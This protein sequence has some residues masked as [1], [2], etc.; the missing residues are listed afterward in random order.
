MPI[1]YT[2]PL[3]S[4][5]N[6]QPESSTS[7]P[8]NRKR[9]YNGEIMG[10]RRSISPEEGGARL[11]TEDGRPI[12]RGEII[13]RLKMNKSQAWTAPQDIHSPVE[14]HRLLQQEEIQHSE[15]HLPLL[16][17]DISTEQDTYAAGIDI[18]RPR[19]ALH[20]GDFRQDGDSSNSLED[21]GSPFA[22]SPPEGEQQDI[23][24]VLSRSHVEQY[25]RSRSGLGSFGSFQFLPPTSPLIHATTNPDLE[26]SFGRQR[27][28]S[29]TRRH[30]FSPFSLQT[31]R[32]VAES[33][34]PYRSSPSHPYQAH[35]PLRPIS[36]PQPPRIRP[37]GISTSTDASPLQH[38]PMVGSYEESILRGRMSTTPSR[39][40]DFIAQLG[41]LG[42]GKC[43][44]SLRCP[45]HVTVPFPAVFYSYNS[46]GRPMDNSPSPYV[47]L[48]DIENSF[49]SYEGKAP[50]GGCYRIPQQGQLQMIIKNPNKTAV[51]LFLVPYNLSDMEPG[52][53]TFIRQR[54]YSAGPMIDMP[55][56]NRKNLGTDRPEAAISHSEDP[57]ERPTLRYLI[58]LHI[59]CPARGRY[60]L[61][62]SIRVVFANRVVDGKEK[63]RNEVQ[64]PEPRYVPYK[65]TVRGDTS[66]MS[67]SPRPAR[68]SSSVTTGSRS[69][70]SQDMNARRRSTPFSFGAIGM[71]QADGLIS[72]PVPLRQPPLS[73]AALQRRLSIPIQQVDTRAMNLAPSSDREDLVAGVG[74]P[75]DED[76]T[77]NTDL[78]TSEP[79]IMETFETWLKRRRGNTGAGSSS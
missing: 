78:I 77:S 1:F 44:P 65:P 75:T 22:A 62:R 35:Q 25:P 15:L 74:L 7:L 10:T 26:I 53:K 11:T 16:N 32:S 45:A 49:P 21:L 67:S 55:I 30:T 73:A 13:E 42:K 59:C 58:H 52:T 9:N 61:Y 51:K 63:L 43:K 23:F 71:D 34:Q 28:P 57:T 68:Q 20:S 79:V 3:D 2:G 37:R 47:G 72:G 27:S 69:G 38:A 66:P 56:S 48:I 40:L 19:S 36:I 50:S 41:V 33:L 4:T 29:P 14:T 31:S 76:A 39:P 12:S 18:A 5:A 17:Q 54:S 8:G 64:L 6:A 46:P 70:L 24:S 60:F